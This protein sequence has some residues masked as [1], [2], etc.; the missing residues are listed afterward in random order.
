[1]GWNEYRSSQTG[2]VSPPDDVLVVRLVGASA[3]A[4]EPGDHERFAHYVKKDKIKSLVSAEN[5]LGLDRSDPNAKDDIATINQL[6]LPVDRP[7]VVGVGRE[8]RRLSCGLYAGRRSGPDVATVCRSVDRDRRHT[9]RH[10]FAPTRVL[11]LLSW[12]PLN[13]QCERHDN[14]IRRGP[15]PVDS[16]V[17]VSVAL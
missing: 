15:P 5:P 9:P 13:R 11:R 17:T 7:A 4:A 8:D 10:R 6:N 1:M 16:I 2:L 3:P 12:L 14:A